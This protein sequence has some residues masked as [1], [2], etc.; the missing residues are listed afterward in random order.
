MNESKYDLSWLF[1]FSLLK[2]LLGGS[3]GTFLLAFLL[4][5]P[6]LIK[7]S[8]QSESIIY[9][10]LTLFS[11]QYDQLGIGFGNNEEID[12]HIQILKSAR[13]LDS[14]DAHFS[15]SGFW[16]IN[17]AGPGGKNLYYRNAGA[18]ISI[19]KT[20][21]SSVSVRV[22]HNDPVLAARIAN[23]IVALGDVI[24]ED[25]LLPNRLEAYNFAKE[26]YESKQ[27]ETEEMAN[28]TSG[29]KTFLPVHWKSGDAVFGER[30]ASA[31]SGL[32]RQ[33]TIYEAELWE[34][35]A[36]KNRY[37][38]LKKSLETPLPRSYIISM[39]VPADRPSWPPRILISI[40]AALS[41]IVIMIFI[42]IIRMDGETE[43]K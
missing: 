35:T 43:G 34:L 39:A 18:M 1:R 2:W 20:R 42:R 30:M 28:H 19:D 33:I 7:P 24:K 17:T 25:I 4:T 22:K 11:R 14:L 36:M 9:V 5:S 23:H 26:L 10:P 27:M 41:F 29:K 3:A 31:D 13:L 15:L 21:Y 40:A 8:Y 37:E 38:L 16:N 32:L 6:V 12:W